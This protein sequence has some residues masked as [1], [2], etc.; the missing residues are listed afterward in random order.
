MVEWWGEEE[1]TKKLEGKAMSVRQ[2]ENLETGEATNGGRR[3][4]V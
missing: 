2:R 3:V 4:P 1:S